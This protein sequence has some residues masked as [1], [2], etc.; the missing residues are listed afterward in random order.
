[1]Y[2]NLFFFTLV[3]AILV[4]GCS[5]VP[6]PIKTSKLEVVKPDSKDSNKAVETSPDSTKSTVASQSQG[7]SDVIKKDLSPIEHVQ[8]GVSLLKF[9]NVNN[10]KA[11]FEAAL[12]KQPDNTTAKKL[13]RQ[14]NLTA[15]EYFSDKPV[16]KTFTAQPGDSFST[17]AAK[18]LNDPLEFHILAKF[19]NYDYSVELVEGKIIK[20]PSAQAVKAPEIIPDDTAESVNVEY[21][22]AKKYYD[23]GRYQSAIAILEPR[24]QSHQNDMQSRDLLVLSY[25]KYAFYLVDKANLLE[26]QTILEK[27]VIIQPDNRQLQSQLNVIEKQRNADRFYTAG[28]RSLK[29][30][31]NEQA[32][33]SFNKA[34][35]LQPDH[36][37]AQKQIIKLKSSVIENLHKMAMTQYSNQD[38]DKAILNWNKVLKLDPNHELA[39]LYRQRA[40]ELKERL[41]KL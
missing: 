14:I 11:E 28:I 20:V 33:D 2:K 16:V 19:N 34:I 41:D 39:K 29:D 6:L 17:V 26:A 36:E 8:Q 30:G 24:I 12:K 27:A 21:N 25:T 31:S 4:T 37:L 22:L 1:M 10:A 13:L 35:K 18:Y 23:Q 40:V 5:P 32:L 15:S 9:G 38:L 7:S 3:F